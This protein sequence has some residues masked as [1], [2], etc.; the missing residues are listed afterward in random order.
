M[1]WNFTK[2]LISSRTS[3]SSTSASLMPRVSIW[4][5]QCALRSVGTCLAYIAFPSTKILSTRQMVT[6]KRSPRVP[7]LLFFV[8]PLQLEVLRSYPPALNTLKHGYATAQSSPQKFMKKSSQFLKSFGFVYIQMLSQ[9]KQHLG[10][11]TEVAYL[12]AFR[13]QRLITVLVVWSKYISSWET[14]LMI[15]IN[16]NCKE[17]SPLSGLAANMQ[18]QVSFFISLL[19]L[20]IVDDTQISLKALPWVKYKRSSCPWTFTITSREDPS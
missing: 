11:L 13:R 9:S 5:L 18:S 7:F 1:Y 19:L 20:S 2:M 14:R 16:E 3:V 8:P 4:L 10:L 17:S 6:R 15:L 12:S